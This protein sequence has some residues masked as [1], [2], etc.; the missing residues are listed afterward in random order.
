MSMLRRAL[1]GALLALGPVAASA[2]VA[3]QPVP[4]DWVHLDAERDGFAG[5]STYRAYEELLA[6]RTPR[7]SVVVAVID[8][9]VDLEHEGLAGRIWRNPGEVADGTDTDGN[10]YVD[11]LHGWN[12]IGGADG[13]HVDYD[14]YEYAREVARL[15]PRFENATEAALSEVDRQKL[16]HYRQMRERLDAR[17]D[18]YAEYFQLVASAQMA[19]HFARAALTAHFGTEAYTTDQ[20]LDLNSTDPQLMQAAEIALYLDANGLTAEAMEQEAERLENALRYS[21]NPDF[22]P[23]H[24]VGDNYDDPTERI[25]GNADV[26]GPDPSH[27]TGVAGAVAGRHDAPYEAFGV[28]ADSVFIMAI[29][30]V[31]NG[32][33]R[34][35][36]VANAIR[37]AAENGAHI[38]NMSFGKAVSPQREVVDE[39][40]RYA[41]SRGVLLVHAAGNDGRDLA[42]EPSFPTRFGPTGE[43]AELWLEVGASTALSEA[44]VASFS[45]Y[46]VREVD[47]FAP[48]EGVRA[49]APGNE[50]NTV[51][52]TSFAAPHVA[53]LA[54][55]LMTHYP[56]LSAGDVRRIILE[57]ATPL[58]DLAVVR[59]GSDEETTFGTLSATGGVINVYE[60]VRRA[61]A[62]TAR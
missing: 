26:G 22:D 55:L 29:R 35:K 52:G 3:P 10:G 20:L 27:G 34:D 6:G 32:D 8:S 38:I 62:F 1:L 21:L 24:I 57:T 23:R 5:M 46:G 58:R 53:G 56:E 36:D 17:R 7:R 54:A 19:S 33:E 49:L 2:Q 16:A 12:F 4:T 48:G 14:T 41:V 28:A 9:G 51:S 30:A 40:I 25:Y 39:A 31:P 15:G 44:L 37:Y 18:E 45:N 61:E 13:S 60:A 42:V 47:V 59:P 43:E 50:A 11:D